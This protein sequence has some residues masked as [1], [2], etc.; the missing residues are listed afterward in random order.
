[1]TFKATPPS[2]LA[3]IKPGDRVRFS[4]RVEGDKNEVTAISK[5]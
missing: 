4:V 3:G 2:L 1:M 5:Q